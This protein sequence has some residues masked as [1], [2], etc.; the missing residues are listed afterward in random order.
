MILLLQC[1]SN[2][3]G[4]TPRYT[5]TVERLMPGGQWRPE[6]AVCPNCI[7]S[8]PELVVAG[9]TL[10]YGTYRVNVTVT[11][12]VNSAAASLV[13]S[14]PATTFLT[15]R[16]SPLHASV[17][18]ATG[19][20]NFK[21]SDTINLNMTGSRDPDVVAS[22]K[23]GIQVRLFCYPQSA[24]ATYETLNAEQMQATATIVANNTCVPSIC[25]S[26]IP[27]SRYSEGPLFLRSDP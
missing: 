2:G 10:W 7:A 26:T 9:N 25:Q 12:S 21:R 3:D 5:W 24:A 22:N 4:A 15:V 23:S 20:P 16:P 6:L 8:C 17:A 14:A 1:T 18:N 11:V 27:Q 19:S 13:R